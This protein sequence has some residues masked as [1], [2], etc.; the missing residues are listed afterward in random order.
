[1]E[2][3]AKGRKVFPGSQELP[4]EF[5]V[6]GETQDSGSWPAGVCRASGLRGHWTPPPC[7][8][9]DTGN[10]GAPCYVT[11][12]EP[13]CMKTDLGVYNMRMIHLRQKLSHSLGFSSLGFITEGRF[14]ICLKEQ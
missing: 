11:C 7:T 13:T 6:S 3:R 5:P 4:G 1:M 10:W 12:S 8:C 2:G 14:R 9:L